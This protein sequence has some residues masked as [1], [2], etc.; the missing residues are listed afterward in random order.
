[1]H[2][3][4]AF[5]GEVPEDVARRAT[6][7]VRAAASSLAPFR[8]LLGELGAFPSERRPRVVWAGM[9]EGE[10]EVRDAALAVRAALRERGVRFDDND[11]TPHLTIARLR[12]DATAEDRAAVAAALGR[13]RAALSALALFEVR[14]IHLMRSVLARSGPTYM[15][16]ATAPLSASP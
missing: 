5:V 2:L 12:D 10:R 11:P 9:R 1:M 3:T 6:E 8:A 15:P 13:N 4:L 7:A 14:E 16:L